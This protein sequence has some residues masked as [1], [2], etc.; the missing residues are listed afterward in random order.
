MSIWK[1]AIWSPAKTLMRG[2]DSRRAV[3][4]LMFT[5]LGLHGLSRMGVVPPSSAWC[6][7]LGWALNFYLATGFVLSRA[8]G[9]RHIERH[10]IQLSTGD[11]SQVIQSRGRDEWGSL[12]G[13]VDQLRQ[14]LADIATG[15]RQASDQLVQ[16]S[17][18]IAGDTRDLSARTEAAAA[19]LE[20]SAA[21][22][23]QTT[24]SIQGI[25]QSVKQSYAIAQGNADVA[26]RAGRDMQG[27]VSVMD[28]IQQSSSKI[29]D[30]IGVIDGIAFQT[31]I[32]ALNAAV[33]AARAGEQGRGFAVVA[34][35]VRSLAQRAGSA[36]R[37]IKSLITVSVENVA[38]GTQAVHETGRT[39]QGVVESAVQLR[40]LLDEIAGA[41]QEQSAGVA[42]IR[43]A[44]QELD[45]NTQANASMV[46]QAAQSAH[47]QQE[48]AIRM[49]ALVDE[50]KLSGAP[51]KATGEF[52]EVE[53]MIEA[54]REWKSR[55]RRALTE[56]ASLDPATIS[57]DDCCALGKQLHGQ[58]QG[59]WGQSPRFTALLQEHAE[60]HR[61][62]GRVA[63][64]IN[65]GD[66]AQ[67]RDLLGIGQPLHRATKRVLNLLSE[68]KRLGFE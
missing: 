16:G 12:L 29:Q 13:E 11:L 65:S 47:D 15:V 39:M 40:T 45:R 27:V 51:S 38:S 22:L 66:K 49:A 25:S 2:W 46:Q 9:T 19:A 54:H 31:N 64:L 67:A 59:R 44:V 55:L 61:R 42:Q 10:L 33:E 63:E 1:W 23:E 26:E 57:R 14:S 48:A 20:Q 7:D 3:A 6:L 24:A 30:I 17:M 37:E 41:V 36:A 62:A 5:G 52:A 28:R 32:L 43:V 50:F 60:F 53:Q 21:A 18:S 8:S 34:S 4:L 35:E 68:V 56:T 58:W